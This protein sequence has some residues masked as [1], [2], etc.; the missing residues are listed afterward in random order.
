MAN[1]TAAG[2]FLWDSQP[3]SFNWLCSVFCKNRDSNNSYFFTIHIK[4]NNFSCASSLNGKSEMK[5]HSK[6]T[7]ACASLRKSTSFHA[8]SS[9][10]QQKNW[11]IACARCTIITNDLNCG[12][13]F[14][15]LRGCIEESEWLLKNRRGRSVQSICNIRRTVRI[16]VPMVINV[17]V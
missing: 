4:L 8:L 12:L 3:Q 13:C 6:T 14:W 15:F 5:I 9:A 10:T 1:L 7:W 11:A 17:N 2:N 16:P